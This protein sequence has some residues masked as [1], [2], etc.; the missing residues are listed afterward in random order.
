MISRPETASRDRNGVKATTTQHG[1]TC[2]QSHAERCVADDRQCVR[3]LGRATHSTG[4]SGLDKDGRAGQ[5]SAWLRPYGGRL[6]PVARELTTTSGP[7]LL[8]EDRQK[9]EVK[10]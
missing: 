7:D 10:P 2:R 5:Q 9:P 6:P 3:A 4:T 1:L 8:T